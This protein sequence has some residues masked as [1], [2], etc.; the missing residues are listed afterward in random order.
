MSAGRSSFTLLDF[1]HHI[2]ARADSAE[3]CITPALIG[4]V[5]VIEEVIVT[6]VDEEL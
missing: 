6:D 5:S 1:V 4:L 3:Y 2:Y